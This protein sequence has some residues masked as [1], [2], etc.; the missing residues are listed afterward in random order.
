MLADGEIVTCLRNTILNNSYYLEQSIMS[1]KTISGT[2]SITL[3]ILT[4]PSPIKLT[5][6]QLQMRRAEIN[7]ICKEPYDEN[8]NI[9]QN[10]SM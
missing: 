9:N 2:L 6:D 1:N 5:R 7:K 3:P 8:N 4:P 10:E